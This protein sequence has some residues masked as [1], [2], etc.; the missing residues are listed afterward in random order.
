MS[1]WSWRILMVW[2]GCTCFGQVD[3]A[4]AYPVGYWAGFAGANPLGSVV[5]DDDFGPAGTNSSNNQEYEF[6]YVPQD[7]NKEWPVCGPSTTNSPRIPVSA[8]GMFKVSSSATI[9]FPN[10]YDNLSGL[11]YLMSS[12]TPNPVYAYRRAGGGNRCACLS[13]YMSPPTGAALPTPSPDP[14]RV[15]A[16]DLPATPQRFYPSTH[17]E[18]AASPPSAPYGPVAVSSNPV[19]DPRK[20]S[21]FHPASTTADYSVCSCPNLNE[22]AQRLSLA[23]SRFGS[24]CVPMIT[25]LT[26]RVLAPY[27]EAAPYFDNHILTAWKEKSSPGPLSNK[28]LLPKDSGAL[29][30]LEPYN[31]RIWTCSAPYEPDLDTGSC[32]YTRKK[33]ACGESASA[34]GIALS[35]YGEPDGTATNLT[36]QKLANKKLACC[37][38]SHMLNA[39]GTTKQDFL[40]YDCIQTRHLD[41][42]GKPVDFN[43]LWA[44][45]DDPLDGGQINALALVSATG[46]PITGFYSLKGSRCG[47]F[48]EF[49]GVLQPKRVRPFLVGAQGATVGGAGIEN[50]GNAY[51]LPSGNAFD[52]LRAGIG[53][54]V[55][56]SLQEMNE[57]PILVRAALVVNCP[58]SSGTLPDPKQVDPNDANVVRCPSAATVTVHLRIEQLFHIAGQAPMKT[59]DTRATQDQIASLQVSEIIGTRFGETCWPGTR[60]VGDACAY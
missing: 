4:W 59:F 46:Q 26:R 2:V 10:A 55:P 16:S 47:M 50:I 24:V 42:A 49:G 33:H 20:F 40:K 34:T 32:V 43:T 58:D 7:P 8:D 51:P 13:D 11:R 35:P 48:S 27:V 3:G 18:I 60:R 56:G 22:K 38:N 9:T 12:P 30:D 31:R 14:T 23:D 39:S 25:D 41:A 5:L 52:A 28:I 15:G 37:M 6:G 19:G 21:R 36:F 17:N 1:S 57:C 44:G 45:G 29:E 54:L 53:K